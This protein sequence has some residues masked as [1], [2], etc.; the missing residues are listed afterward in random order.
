MA[1]EQKQIKCKGFSMLQKK[2]LSRIPVLN[3]CYRAAKTEAQREIQ[4]FS[5]KTG[6]LERQRILM[7]GKEFRKRKR[8][9]ALESTSAGYMIQK[10][11]EMGLEKAAR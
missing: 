1:R 10:R 8:K 11:G 3:I 4:F 6:T 2:C 7:E 9:K 5:E